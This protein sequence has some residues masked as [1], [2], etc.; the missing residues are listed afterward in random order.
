MIRLSNS[1]L[2]HPRLHSHDRPLIHGREMLECDATVTPPL[3]LSVPHIHLKTRSSPHPYTSTFHP[4]VPSPQHTLN[5]PLKFAPVASAAGELILCS[6]R[7]LKYV[8][9]YII[10]LG[11]LIF[12]FHSLSLLANTNK[13]FNVFVLVQ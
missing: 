11:R 7:S 12:N 13:Y 6:S 8:L 4:D 9:F 1:F 10:F 5:S 3:P 2:I